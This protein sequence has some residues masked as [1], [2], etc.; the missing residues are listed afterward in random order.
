MSLQD[1]KR[2]PSR[3]VLTV[4][5][6][7]VQAC[8]L[9]STAPE[10]LPKAEPFPLATLGA[11]VHTDNADEHRNR[12]RETQPVGAK[13]SAIPLAA[14]EGDDVQCSRFQE[15]C[16][17]SGGMLRRRQQC[18]MNAGNLRSR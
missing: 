16:G 8:G 5:S 7:N 3:L 4:E 13:L 11:Q 6:M 15:L 17:P 18:H 9:S 1:K 10:S 14:E 2:G 12:R